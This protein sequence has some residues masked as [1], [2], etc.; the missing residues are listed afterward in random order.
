[1]RILLAS[2]F[3]DDPRLGSPKVTHKLRE[4]FRAAGHTCDALFADDLGRWPRQR[5]ARDVLAAV[6]TSRAVERA[7]R[8]RGPYDVVDVAGAEGAV[9]AVRHRL[10]SHRRAA[11]ISRSNGLEHLNYRRMLDDHAEGVIDKPWTRRIWYP[12]VRL[13]QVAV[14]LRCADRVILLNDI[15]RDYVTAR[16]W[17]PE[18]RLDVVPHGISA[19]FVGRREV[20]D[21]P[22]GQGVLFCGSWDGLKGTPYIIAALGLALA[23]GAPFDLTVLGGGRPA[24]RIL[25]DFPPDTRPFVRILDRASEDEVMRQYRLHDLLVFA[26]TYEGFGMVVPEAM[27]QGLPVVATPVGAAATLVRDGETG[28]AVPARDAAALSTAV[29]RL[30]ADAPLGRRLAAAA[31]DAVQDLTWERTAGATLD[32]YERALAETRQGRSADAA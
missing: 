28:L 24:D 8:E 29:R 18:T 6:L 26:S 27:S 25:A 23:A 15:D 16:G 20:L 21:A 22:R 13:S 11:C 31:F 9:V 2:D 7:F 3:P 19:R 30:L 10:G 14:A 32:V 1:M 5:H 12:M 4:A 17:V